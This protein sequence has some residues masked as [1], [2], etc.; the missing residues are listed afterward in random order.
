[1][2]AASS[3]TVVLFERHHGLTAIS[4]SAG[5]LLAALRAAGLVRSWAGRA[6]IAE[7]DE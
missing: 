4:Y 3:E 6:T 1:M 2:S 5:T 7:E